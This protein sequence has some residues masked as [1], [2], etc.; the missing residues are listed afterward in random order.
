MEIYLERKVPLPDQQGC[1]I[2][3]KKEVKSESKRV[4]DCLTMTSEGSKEWGGE[5]GE[6]R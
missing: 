1:P 4:K 6:Q 3:M 2:L 5:G